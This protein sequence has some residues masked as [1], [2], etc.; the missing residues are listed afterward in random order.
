MSSTF[1]GLNIG[2]SGLFA[3]KTGLNTTAH[4][5]ANIETV[6]YSR[7]IVSQTADRALTTNNT[8]GMIG[9]GV[10]VNEI[11]Q[12][13]SRYY[14]EKYRLNNGL[15]GQYDQRS[16]FLTEVESYLNEIKLDG[17][18]TTFDSMYNSIQE[19]TKD[20]SNLT[21]RSTVSHYAES[22]CEYFNSLSTN[23]VKIQDECNYEVKNQVDRVNSLAN[24]IATLTKQINTVEVGGEN[25][26]DL[27][28]QREELVDELSNI[29]NVSVDEE[30]FGNSGMKTY[31]VRIN[32]HVLVD[33]YDTNL[34][35][36]K[37][38]SVPYSQNDQDGLYDIFWANGEKLDASNP[39]MSGTIRALYEV[40]DGN[41]NENLRGTI[42]TELGK[43]TD[44]LIIRN[45]NINDV[46]DLNIPNEGMI[47]VGAGEYKYDSYTVTVT[48]DGSYE[49]AFHL[50]TD[51]RK[52][53]EAGTSVQIGEGIGYKGIPYY[54]AKL[55]EF[56][57]VFAQEFN[58]L[59]R[60]GVDLN[61]DTDSNFFTA[62]NKI[63]GEEINLK[64]IGKEGKG[65]T[66][67]DTFTSD[68]NVSS[69]AYQLLTA[70]NFKVREI[71]VTNPACLVT[72]TDIVNGVS[73]ADIAKKLLDLKGDIT[74]FKQ[75]DPA[76]FLQSLVGEIGVDTKAASD[77]A[78]SQDNIVKNVS[79][80]RLSVAGVDSDEEAMSLARY[81]EAYQLSA[82]VVSV[83]ND[84]FNVLIN[85]MIV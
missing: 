15:L 6:G 17:F 79:K 63:T 2:A 11:V 27:R 9:T 80:Q 38:R 16:H 32:K 13:R 7:Q 25:A 76:E 29:I 33:T 14:D 36:V 21:V 23:L 54:Q 83:M 58:A 40:R 24:Q 30:T 84:I 59:H 37:P 22:L 82:K 43:N 4:N 42:Y 72:A 64:F 8:Y 68:I 46:K 75:G 18:V 61:G 73:N 47:K 48:E 67:S 10:S 71:M 34:L 78:K 41:D 57:R 44:T 53:Y 62:T 52:T 77:F 39:T 56:I 49:Y 35:Y 74:M 85:E 19:L 60:S 28:D 55:N 81:Q 31:V 26:N 50:T 69:G 20:P 3:A 70:S 12:K 1:F 66:D 65:R 51:A 5:V 45:T